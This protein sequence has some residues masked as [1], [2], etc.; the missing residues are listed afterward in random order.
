[1]TTSVATDVGKYALLAQD[2]GTYN[3]KAGQVVIVMEH[4]VTTGSS[5]GFSDVAVVKDMDAAKAVAAAAHAAGDTSI[6]PELKRSADQT[7]TDLT[8]RNLGV[9]M[10]AGIWKELFDASTPVLTPVAGAPDG[11]LALAPAAAS[12]LIGKSFVANLPVIVAGSIDMIDSTWTVDSR[13]SA[14]KLRLVATVAGTAYSTELADADVAK[15]N[16]VVVITDCA[17]DVGAYVN[18][19]KVLNCLVTIGDNIQARVI[20]GLAKDIGVLLAPAALKD[21]APHSVLNRH[22][23]SVVDTWESWFEFLLSSGSVAVILRPADRSKVLAQLK[24]AKAAWEAS[25]AAPPLLPPAPQAGPLGGGL[26]LPPAAVTPGNVIMTT[27]NIP[28]LDALLSLALDTAARD[29]FCVDVMVI[30]EP[31]ASVRTMICAHKDAMQSQIERWLRPF[32]SATDPI[33]L[34]GRTGG[35]TAGEL[36]SFCLGLRASVTPTPAGGNG[37]GAAGG[38]VLPRIRVNMRSSTDAEQLTMS[39]SDKR[40]RTQMQSDFQA[41]EDDAPALKRLSDMKVLADAGGIAAIEKVQQMVDKESDGALRR[42]VYSAPDPSSVTV[43]AEPYTV[44]ALIS[45]RGLLDSRLERSV[46]GAKTSISSDQV[47]R[48]LRWV[49]LRRIGRVRLAELMDESDSG[50]EALPLAQFAKMDMEKAVSLFTLAL[51]RLQNAWVFSAPAHSGQAM[52]FVSALQTKCL[53]ALSDGVSWADVGIFYRAVIRRVDRGANGF[54]GAAAVL[55]APDP[56]WAT[57]HTLEWVSDLRQNSSEAI[58]D[59]KHQSRLD[60]LIAQTAVA[61]KDAEAKRQKDADARA[62]AEKKRKAGA[63][64]AN[65]G[66]KGGANSRK[67]AKKGKGGNQTV[68]NPSTAMVVADTAAALGTGFDLKAEMAKLEASMGKYAAGKAPCYFHHT[69][70]KKCRFDAADCRGYH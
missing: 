57:D 33:L 2:S 9:L 28:R 65:G 24:A 56:S 49:R 59:A 22:S 8:N 53:A 14:T 23:V 13:A 40:D 48:Q 52:M 37:A 30:I 29:S 64:G 69:P 47:I 67:K 50:T 6:V 27:S 63:D 38:L 42:L 11:G 21:D 17:V 3:T 62:A 1:M 61:A 32:G 43:D 34:R 31:D 16:A 51:N 68:A 25:V 46:C 18:V 41:L 4:K 39:E 12:G 45:I 60:A 10:G 19:R 15:F 54:A 36:L 58:S 35:Q 66:A 70:G 55:E 5:S 20:F 7:F 26:G 44:H